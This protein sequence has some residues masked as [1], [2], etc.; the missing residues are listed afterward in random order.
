MSATE[1]RHCPDLHVTS[2]AS[3]GNRE[4]GARPRHRH[5]PAVHHRRVL[6]VH[7]R[8]GTPRALT[9]RARPSSGADYESHAA[10]LD[11]KRTRRATHSRRARA[12][13]RAY[14][15]LAARAER[16]AV[17]EASGAGIEHLGLE[18]GHRTLTITRKGGEVVTICSRR[19]LPGRSTWPSASVPAHRC[20]YP[21]NALA[22][23]AAARR[24]QA[25]PKGRIGTRL[26]PRR[27]N[28]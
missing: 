28:K 23:Q 17:S 6:S 10:A 15:G 19:A 3:P 21:R 20:S 24:C 4:Q 18:R 8:R 14:A 11:L 12:A 7:G 5:P 13:D 16:P 2:K 22:G 9:S 27:C 26:R 1:P 25:Q